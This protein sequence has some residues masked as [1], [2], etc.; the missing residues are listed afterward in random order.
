M[1]ED[2]VPEPLL[3]IS[4]SDPVFSSRRFEAAKQKPSLFREG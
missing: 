3:G 2:A 1:L 4:S